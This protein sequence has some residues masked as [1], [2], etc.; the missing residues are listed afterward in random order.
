MVTRFRKRNSLATAV[1]WKP[2]TML[3]HDVLKVFGGLEGLGAS[4]VA[5]KSDCLVIYFGTVQTYVR[6]FD[7]DWIVKDEF[8]DV[9]VMSDNLFQYKYVE[10]KDDVLLVRE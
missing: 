7:G 10:V 5:R 2:E 4:K 9:V 6:A 3:I 1:Q 8:G